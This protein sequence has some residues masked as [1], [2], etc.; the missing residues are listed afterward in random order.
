MAAGG[1]FLTISFS[2]SIC[3]SSLLSFPLLLLSPGNF[4]FL[5]AFFPFLGL[6][7]LAGFLFNQ[8][9]KFYNSMSI[10]SST[11]IF[12][13]SSTAGLTKF[14]AISIS[15]FYSKFSPSLSFLFQVYSKSPIFFY[16]FKN[17]SV[18]PVGLFQS[19]NSS[20]SLFFAPFPLAFGSAL[21]A[22]FLASSSY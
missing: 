7:L 1:N 2:T 6:A 4:F 12:I 21:V 22:F 14:F 5:P 18:G 8:I 16:N 19:K 20:S 3:K 17:A 10:I 9:L 15:Y 13:S 11:I